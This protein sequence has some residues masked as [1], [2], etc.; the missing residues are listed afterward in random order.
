[1]ISFT[2]FAEICRCSE[3]EQS[4]ITSRQYKMGLSIS[5][6]S[7]NPLPP[8]RGPLPLILLP[9]A[10]ISPIIPAGFAALPMR[11]QNTTAHSDFGNN[12]EQK[13]LGKLQDRHF[14][15]NL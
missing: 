9:Q 2:F 12:L 10:N 3:A 15:E 8:L 7:V 4:T 13:Y 1:M 14:H 5:G 6:Q 11:T